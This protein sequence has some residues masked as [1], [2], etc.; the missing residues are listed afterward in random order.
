MTTF[1]K[2]CVTL[3]VQRSHSKSP[4]YKFGGLRL[5]S[6]RDIENLIFHVALQ[7]LVIKG[8][9]DFMERSSSFYILTLPSVVAI[10]IVVVDIKWF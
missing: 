6:S 5:F 3:W 9:F 2:D 10:A 1:S 7:D 4:P 8:P